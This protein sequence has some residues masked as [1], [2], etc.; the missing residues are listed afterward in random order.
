MGRRLTARPELT[1]RGNANA[2]RHGWLRLTP[3]YSVDL[4]SSVLEKLSLDTVVCDPF[5]GTG[6]TV[7]CA[8]QR[9]FRCTGIDVNP[10]LVWLM[11][12]K[13]R[14]YSK[15]DVEQAHSLSR[16]VNAAAIR[17]SPLGEPSP[18]IHTIERWWSSADIGYL[19]RLRSGIRGL[20][21]PSRVRDLL[22]VAYCRVIIQ[23]ANVS[24]GHQSLSFRQKDDPR[25]KPQQLDLGFSRDPFLAAMESVLTAVGENP[26]ARPR[27][28]QDDSRRLARIAD[29][30][31]DLILTS[32]PYP[33]RVTTIRELR[34]YMYWQGYL[35]TP[36][37]AG[38]LDWRAIG[39]T[40]GAA[41]SRLTRWTRQEPLPAVIDGVCERI[42]AA[43][44]TNGDLMA[45]YV[46]RYFCD[47]QEHFR[48]AWRILRP[49]GRVHY[50]VGN[51]SFYGHIVESEKAFVE[52][53]R[54]VGFRHVRA[55]AIRKRYS[56]DALFEFAVT[57]SK[58][59]LE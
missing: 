25:A 49:G 59:V 15:A 51:A 43:S 37:D 19:R 38:E 34:P 36:S 7:L 23:T 50:I 58:P 31:I 46:E 24:R 6:T 48:N 1:A 13:V 27:V 4:V 18:Q 8:V 22:K 9:G 56:N 39:G 20:R 57:A 55:V 40:W 33:N 53:L 3:A 54:A 32:P 28:V 11:R 29:A 21:A 17:R 45:R 47:M 35:V 2:G 41:T 12:A 42:R 52:Q 14:R 30:S 26:R 16:L 10:F 5:A 44:P